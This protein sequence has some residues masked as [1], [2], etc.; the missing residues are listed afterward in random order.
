MSDNY[1]NPAKMKGKQRKQAEAETKEWEKKARAAA[2]E[3]RRAQSPL[4]NLLG[5]DAEKKAIKPTKPKPAS[6]KE[7]TPTQTAKAKPASVQPPAQ[8][9]LL[10]PETVQVWQ[11][12]TEGAVTK[13]IGR[14]HAWEDGAFMDDVRQATLREAHPAAN[15][16]FWVMLTF[17]GL[18]LFWMSVA[19]LDEVTSGNGVVIPTGKIQVV[20]N[21]EGGIVEE[22]LVQEGDIVAQ[23]QPLILI[24]DT[25]FASSFEEKQQRLWYLRASIARLQAL[26]QEQPLALPEDLATSAPEVLDQALDL[27]TS[28]KQE[29]ASAQ[30]VLK[31][32]VDQRQQDFADAQQRKAQTREAYQLAQQELG[33]TAPLEKEGVISKVELLR[34]QRE[35]SELKGQMDT[36]SLAVP[37]AEAALEE[38]KSRLEESTL[39]FQNEARAELAEYQGELDRLQEVLKAEGDKVARATVRAPVRG[40][41]KQMLVN[42]LGQ[43]IQPGMDLIELV[44]L[45]ETLLVEA[46]IRPNDIAFLRPGQKATVKISAYDFAIYGGLPAHLVRISPDTIIEETGPFRGE[47]FY[48]IQVRTERNYLGEEDDPLPIIPGMVGAV[49]ILTG[50]KTVL[51]YML[52]P[53]NKAREKALRER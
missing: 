42:T 50:K 45:D 38:A 52:K 12:K 29:L 28:R 18:S 19:K 22:I 21:L 44:P 13:W 8:K 11:A 10:K 41:V 15:L 25:G 16:L 7:T 31:R 20:Q 46:K 34:L 14:Y 36:A 35:V 26:I 5:S 40:E 53:L 30:D 51:D 24:D 47:P 37:S 3:E 4:N 32:Q 48:K 17:I 6:S 49:D 9:E 2:R 27:Y 23:G 1:G 39:R 43:V 33:M